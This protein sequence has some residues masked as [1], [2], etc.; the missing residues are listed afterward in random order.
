MSFPNKIKPWVAECRKKKLLALIEDD[1][2]LHIADWNPNIKLN[3]AMERLKINP[4]WVHAIL[5]CIF[6][7]Y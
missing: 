3:K 5:I 1:A 4:L 6:C 2:L 7:N